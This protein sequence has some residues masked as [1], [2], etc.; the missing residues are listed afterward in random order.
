M[1]SEIKAE[2]IFLFPKED[3][4]RYRALIND[5]TETLTTIKNKPRHCGDHRAKYEGLLKSVELLD[6]NVQDFI[7]ISIVHKSMIEPNPVLRNL[8][9]GC[10][11][12]VSQRIL[13]E[14]DIKGQFQR[15]QKDLL[16]N[17]NIFAA[18]IHLY[19]FRTRCFSARGSRIR[20]FQTVAC[21]TPNC[22]FLHNVHRPCSAFSETMSCHRRPCL[23]VHCCLLCS[24]FPAFGTG[25]KGTLLT[26]TEDI[27][28]CGRLYNLRTLIE[29]SMYGIE[30]PFLPYVEYLDVFENTVSF[31]FNT[32][33]P[34]YVNRSDFKE[35]IRYQYCRY[36]HV[37]NN[38]NMLF[39]PFKVDNIQDFPYMEKSKKSQVVLSYGHVP[40]SSSSK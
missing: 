28:L 11:S 13:H 10:L 1:A 8:L 20:D 33:L 30:N 36:P 34:F 9:Y 2:N 17:S 7:R 19:A 16:G 22:K 32:F 15:H 25:C 31:F 39:P 26:P 6:K 23:D 18:I 14:D 5:I 35:F 27:L 24:V 40:C 37:F 29:R 21:S 38:I 12:L 3:Y 4:L